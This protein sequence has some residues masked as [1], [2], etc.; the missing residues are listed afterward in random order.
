MQ[1]ISS[2]SVYSDMTGFLTRA[3]AAIGYQIH[4]SMEEHVTIRKLHRKE[5]IFLLAE[6]PASNVNFIRR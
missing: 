2:V 3:N 1:G 6:V 4:G 5:S